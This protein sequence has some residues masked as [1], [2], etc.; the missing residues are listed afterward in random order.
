MFY[1]FISSLSFLTVATG[2]EEIISD[3]AFQ[4]CIKFILNGTTLKISR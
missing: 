3:L 4:A 2:K 1:E